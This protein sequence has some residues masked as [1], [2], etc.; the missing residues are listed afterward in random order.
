MDPN[1]S[2]VPKHTQQRVAHTQYRL[3]VEVCRH[4][5]TLLGLSL[6]VLPAADIGSTRQELCTKNLSY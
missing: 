4:V 5:C 1:S 6:D 2:S 3:Y